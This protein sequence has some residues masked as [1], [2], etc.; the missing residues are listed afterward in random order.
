L[1][2][3]AE[4]VGVPVEAAAPLSQILTVKIAIP[5]RKSRDAWPRHG[6]DGGNPPTDWS[7]AMVSTTLFITAC[8]ISFSQ[9]RQQAV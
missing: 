9:N 8:R 2:L 1:W 3:P 6:Y 7:A 4:P 5:W